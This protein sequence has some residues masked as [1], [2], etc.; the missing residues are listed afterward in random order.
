MPA[1]FAPLVQASSRWVAARALRASFNLF[2]T[3]I[4][5][6]KDRIDDAVACNTGVPV[7][8]GY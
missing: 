5:Q 1:P 7:F 8:R 3:C 2:P 6:G 4:H